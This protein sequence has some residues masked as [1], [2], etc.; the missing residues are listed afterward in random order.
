MD[1]IPYVYPPIYSSH[2]LSGTIF[3]LYANLLV[4]HTPARGVLCRFFMLQ[5]ARSDSAAITISLSLSADPW[6]LEELWVASTDDCVSS[7]PHRY[8]Q[9]LFDDDSKFNLVICLRFAPF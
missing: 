3:T 7:I 4:Q 8:A 6:R 2:A 5:D 9:Q 1:A